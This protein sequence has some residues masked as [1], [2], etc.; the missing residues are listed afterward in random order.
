[1]KRIIVLLILF[2]IVVCGSGIVGIVLYRSIT[3]KF[4]SEHLLSV[5]KIEKMGKL[6][7]VKVNIKDVLEQT[8]E[9]PFYLPNAKAVLIIAGEVIAGID[10]EK[11]Q[12]EDISDSG[13]ELTITLPKPEVLMSKVNH[14]KSKI[15]NI[16]WGGFSTASLVDEAYK[17]AERRIIEEAL[18][19]GYEET[20]K[21]NART[22]LTPIFREISG[23]EINILF[24]N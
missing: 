5:E 18:N 24:K 19:T 10:L 22:L 21:N 8:G 13:T 16:E 1:M 7:L 3:Q 4:R 17:A 2:I 12:K 15:Y 14:E 23:K 6:E 20:C 9:R 11:V